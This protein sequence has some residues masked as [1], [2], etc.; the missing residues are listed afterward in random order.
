MEGNYKKWIN[1]IN[2]KQDVLTEDNVGQ[3]MDLKLST[4]NTPSTDDT[5]LGRDS[6]TGKAVEIPTSSLG[7]NGNIDTSNLVPYTGANKDVN[8]GAYYFETSQGFKKTGG[9]SNQFLMADGNTNTYGTTAGTVAEGNHTHTFASIT[10]KPTSLS[11]YGITDGINTSDVVTTATANKILKLDANAKLPT[12]ITGNADG[13]AATA[14]KLQTA[15]TINGV[16]FDGSADITINAGTNYTLPTASATVLG[17]V[18]I[19]SGISIDGNGV[20]SAN[21]YTAGTENRLAKFSSSTLTNSIIYDDGTNVGIGT[22][23]LGARLDVKA[24]GALSTD[25]AFRVRNS[26]N[27][28]NFL[29]VTGAGEVYNRGAKG[30]EF[31]TFFGEYSGINSTGGSNNAFGRSALASNTTGNGNSAFGNNVLQDNTTGDSNNAFGAQSLMRNITGNGNNAFGYNALESNTEGN[32]NIAIGSVA[33]G[34][35]T[36]GNQNTALGSGAGDNIIGGLPNTTPNNSVFI[37]YDTTANANNETNQIVIGHSARGD[38]SNSVVL[39]NSS[40]TRTRLQGQVIIG[41]FT[42]PPSGIEGAIYYNS[43]TKKHYG[44]DGT[45]WN[46]YDHSQATITVELISQLTTNF[47]APNA[48]RINSTSLISGSGTLTLKV[49]DVAYTLGNLIPQGAK[50]TAETSSSSVYNLISIYE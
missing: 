10:S 14:T 39:G 26:T 37:G 38:G 24:Q 13:N 16:S 8:I 23:T 27:T 41:S 47:Y 35:N 46:A 33:L 6:L 29:V 1:R 17:G 48:L 7:G 31:N 44:F 19:G 3:F 18:K 5:V 42:S 12:S 36:T 43:T 45:S 49:N 50:I 30:N 20:I 21:A 28:Q 34:H 25:I 40:I 15:R 32:D 9:T 4:K 2:S 22:T 11:G